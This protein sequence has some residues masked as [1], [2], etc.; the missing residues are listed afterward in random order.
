M[1]SQEQ[2]C[3]RWR[4]LAQ[5]TVWKSNV[6]WCVDCI[7]PVLVVLSVVGFAMILWL[8][9]HGMQIGLSQFWPWLLVGLAVVILTGMVMARRNFIGLEEALVRLEYQLRL[10]NGLTVARLGKGLW[11]EIP[12]EIKDGW[13]WHWRRIVTPALLAA[14]CLWAAVAIPVSKS[15]ELTVPTM[16]PQA[17]AQM[18]QWLEKLN[19]HKIITPEKKAEQ[20]AKIAELREQPKEK[21]FS[22]ES[23]NAGDTLKEQLQREIQKLGSDLTRAEQSLN[24]MQNYADKLSQAAKD[25]LLKEFSGSVEGLKGNN[26][27]I[28]RELLKELSQMDLNSLSSMSREQLDQLRES[29]KDKADALQE[30]AQGSGFLGD[31]Q[32]EDDELAEML[33]QQG[34]GNSSDE[35][36]N[37]GDGP[38]SGGVDRGPGTAPLSLSPDENRF[39][40]NKREALSNKD[41]SRAMPGTTLT[42][43]DGKHEVD[44][45]YAGPTAAGKVQNTGQ[46]GEQVWHDALTPEERAV[47]KRVFK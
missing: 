7:T 2:L 38:G 36:V 23:L 45:N 31:G 28:D 25:R 46:G 17:W 44:K 4:Q 43:Q 35:G 12:D 8:R 15:E 37:N 1:N 24:A 33:G 27:E 13:Q 32:G 22:H 6:A 3:R 42:L 41:M 30:L 10:N 34:K 26:L 18:D 20:D 39:D 47:L 5:R 29:L 19:D 40:T 11:P 14:M 9:S 16:E 21:W